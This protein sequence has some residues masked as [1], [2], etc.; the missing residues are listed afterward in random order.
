MNPQE[1]KSARVSAAVTPSERLKVHRVANAVDPKGGVSALL[2]R[3]SI[4][5]ALAAYDDLEKKAA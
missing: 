1:R 2:R 3:L 5:E 4:T